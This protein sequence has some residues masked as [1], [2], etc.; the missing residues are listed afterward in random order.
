MDGKF[1]FTSHNANLVVLTDAEQIALFDS[2]G[3]TGGVSARG[4]LCTSASSITEHVIATLDGGAV[5]VAAEVPEVRCGEPL[6]WLTDSRPALPSADDFDREVGRVSLRVYGLR[7]DVAGDE[8]LDLVVPQ[9]GSV[10]SG[11]A[12][13]FDSR[14]DPSVLEIQFV[15][16]D[17]DVGAGLRFGVGAFQR[18]HVV[19]QR[20]HVGGQAVESLVRRCQFLRQEVESPGRLG[21]ELREQGGQFEQL[22]S[23]E[24]LAQ[25]GAPF[26]VPLECGQ[27][28]LQAPHRDIGWCCRGHR[29]SLILRGVRAVGNPC[30]RGF[31]CLVR[32][33]MPWFH[34]AW[35]YA[36]GVRAGFVLR[37]GDHGFVPASAGLPVK[38]RVPPVLA[39]GGVADHSVRPRNRL[40]LL[41]LGP[42]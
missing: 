28:V 27:D 6:T 9:V 2:D 34:A 15:G 12:P 29:L 39:G 41:H 19:L 13:E 38:S 26:R 22:L 24:L 10:V 21:G 16:D 25:R 31:S 7:H 11:D 42:W 36:S 8:A 35:A 40:D 5:S 17:R 20:A 33:W 23:E 18:A 3:S 14:N 37:P 32:S 30:S 1:A 4:F